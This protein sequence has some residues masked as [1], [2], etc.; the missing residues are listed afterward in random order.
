M[1]RKTEWK[2]LIDVVHEKHI[3]YIRQDTVDGMAFHYTSPNG[4]LGI[5]SNQS[6]W[7]NNSDFLNDIS[8]SDYFFEISSKIGNSE[9][10]GKRADNLAFRTYLIS[11]FHSN[12]DGRGRETFSREKE[13][14]YIFSLSLDNDSLSLWNY[15]T[16]TIDA[17]GYN[18]GIDLKRMTDSFELFSNQEL[19]IGRVIYDC[20]K[21]KELLEELYNDYLSIYEQYTYSYQRKYLYNSLEDNIT[22]YSMFMKNPAAAM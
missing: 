22:K 17:T 5:I 19:L 10:R 7:F 18:I 21:Q 12:A 11:M 2:K 15:Y 1:K 13:R 3:N 8:E 9:N 16:K 4:L 20:E 6:I 14:R